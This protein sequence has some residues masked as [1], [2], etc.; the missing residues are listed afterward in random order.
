MTPRLFRLALL[1][2]TVALVAFGRGQLP[3][4]P[5]KWTA[6][7]EPASAAPGARVELVLHADVPAPWHLYSLTPV[8]DG[9]FT[10]QIVVRKGGAIAEVGR[11]TQAEPKRKLDKNFGKEVEYYEGSA[12]FRVPVRLAKTA[13]GSAKI[14]A[15]VRY[16]LGDEGTCLPPTSADA[17]L[18]VA[19]TIAVSGTAI[20]DKTP[21][22][23]PSAAVVTAAKSIAPPANAVDRAKSQ[24]L[25]AYLALAVGFGFASLLTPCVFPMIPITVSFF[26][27]QKQG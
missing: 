22:D 23:S 24:G 2:W 3:P 16:Q 9:P 18:K 6:T 5:A 25:L 12:E 20:D 15:A 21:L 26:S 8:P 27:K 11:P 7:V 14:E 19:G 13:S 1:L 17:P 10:T 4:S